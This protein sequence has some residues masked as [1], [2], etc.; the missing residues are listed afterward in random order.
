M[1]AF[2]LGR[3]SAQETQGEGDVGTRG[4]HVGLDRLS[5]GS[6]LLEKLVMDYEALAKREIIFAK[7]QLALT[8]ITTM[9]LLIQAM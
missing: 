2:E 6:E 3:C 4:I 5:E 7:Q 1:E 9:F 8:Y